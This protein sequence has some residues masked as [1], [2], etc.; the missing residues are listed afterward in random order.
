M[1]LLCVWFCRRGDEYVAGFLRARSK[2]EGCRLRELPVRCE[3][4][5]SFFSLITFPLLTDDHFPRQARDK[6][7]QRAPFS[8]DDSRNADFINST[9]STVW[10]RAAVAGGAFWHYSSALSTAAGSDTL[11]EQVVSGIKAR[12]ARRGIGV[13][14]CA[15]GSVLGCE[16]NS[17]CGHVWCPGG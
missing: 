3:K 9:T 13:C 7:T 2:D 5:H 4:T 10:P 8:A 14:P 11:F 1:L 16:Q 12:L 6:Q 17:Y 15:T